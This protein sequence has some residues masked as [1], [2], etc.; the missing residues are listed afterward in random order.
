MS[1]GDLI[2]PPERIQGPDEGPPWAGES[3]LVIRGLNYMLLQAVGAVVQ[4]QHDL[5][6]ERYILLAMLRLLSESKVEAAKKRVADA[7][8]WVARTGGLR[9]CTMSSMCA[10]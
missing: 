4:L 9:T 2:C 8:D 6:V 5:R 7:A 10:C 1:A 3:G